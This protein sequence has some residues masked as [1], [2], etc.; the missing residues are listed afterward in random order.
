MRNSVL[1]FLVFTNIT[2]GF[3]QTA[4][5]LKLNLKKGDT[6]IIENNI[7]SETIQDIMGEKQEIK[8]ND[9]FQYY[10]SVVKQTSDSSYYIKITY[11]R[12]KSIIEAQNQIEIFDTDSI[13]D[14][15]P[16]SRFFLS[17]INKSFYFETNLKGK[18]LKI[19]SFD[20]V[21]N[22]DL[23]KDLD[24]NTKEVLKKQF[25]KK[26]IKEMTLT[27]RFP[28]KKIQEKE[29]W[30]FNDTVNINILNIF[31][32]IHKLQEITKD[33]YIV[34]RTAEIFTDKNKSL[35][36]NNIFINYDMTGKSVGSDVLFKNSCMIKESVTTQ[37]ISGTVGMKYSESSETAYTWPIEITNKIFVK[38]YKIE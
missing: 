24:E 28:V 26:A 16:L 11:K 32:S 8:K 17:F 15:S 21:F 6:Y 9:F 13:N 19:D 25:G 5:E 20:N 12:F 10:F 37:H 36:I 30:S 3:S 34:N 18:I 4:V 7:I 22:L 31:N 29:T 1:I 14:N 38:A 35:K 33:T 23:I 2:F 27:S